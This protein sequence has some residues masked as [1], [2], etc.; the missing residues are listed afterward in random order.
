VQ[1]AAAFLVG[2]H[3]FSAFKNAGRGSA[4]ASKLQAKKAALGSMQEE[5]SS[6]DPPAHGAAGDVCELSRVEVRPVARA[7]AAHPA[8]SERFAGRGVSDPDSF[9]HELVFVGDRFLYK[10]V[11]NLVGALVE[12]AEGGRP[13]EDLKVALETGAWPTA[14]ARGKAGRG[15]TAR[16]AGA[17]VGRPVCAPPQG[18][19]L[20]GVSFERPA[21]APEPQAIGEAFGMSAGGLQGGSESASAGLEPAGLEPAA[22]AGS[23][24]SF[25]TRRSA[26]RHLSSAAAVAAFLGA[27]CRAPDPVSAAEAVNLDRAL[28]AVVKS[29]KRVEA[30]QAALWAAVE[31]PKKNGNAGMSSAR[32][33]AKE[34]LRSYKLS[35]NVATA[36]KIL[37]QA[38]RD[39]A[40]VEAIEAH[41]R[42][43]VFYLGMIVEY[44]ALDDLDFDY[45]GKLAKEASPEKLKF[46]Q[47]AAA[48]AQA[49][50]G[51]FAAA[52]DAQDLARARELVEG[53]AAFENGGF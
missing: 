48:Q 42:D 2:Q 24:G 44:D 11:R 9:A 49:E 26:L 53:A 13:A 27:G 15:G 31:D 16:A 29:A 36:V 14:E 52:F 51:R 37:R 43:A 35:E 47:R 7:T 17:K 39:A 4:R 10:M 50:L 40:A 20:H 28:V 21:L 23:T 19:T 18:L 38:R 33:G 12:V 5:D 25:S 46:L 45:V 8:R 41:G 22:A 30:M 32:T 34:C 1:A 6:E 3:D